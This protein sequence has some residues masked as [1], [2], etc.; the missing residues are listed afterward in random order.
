MVES[1]LHYSVSVA[2]SVEEVLSLL[3]DSA[4]VS[5]STTIRAPSLQSYWISAFVRNYGLDRKLA[6]TLVAN[7]ENHRLV[8]PFQILE[9]GSLSFVCDETSDYNDLMFHC[10]GAESVRIAFAH[11]LSTGIRRFVLTRLPH[12]ATTIAILEA[13]ARDLGLRSSVC[14]CDYLPV[15]RTSADLPVELWSGVDI[16][17]IHEFQKKL[18]VLNQK[19]N[20][21]FHLV[22]TDVELSIMLPQ[23]MQLH[24]ERWHAQ[25]NVSKFLDS[26]RC[27]FTHD[28]CKAALH[29]GELFAAL[30]L[31]DGVIGSYRLGFRGGDTIFEWN[32][33]FASTFRKW[34]PGALLLLMILHQA[35]ELGY[36]KY[37]LMRGEEPYKYYWTDQR[38]HTITVTLQVP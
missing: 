24:V 26:R 20:V 18:R 9:P 25:G 7:N 35:K 27:N 34:S 38:E 29:R 14:V 10:S 36:R 17:R 13:V 23:M 12:D 31:I 11:W 4:G 6:F 37:N 22:E 21:T 1:P 5:A 3:E 30:M 28:I 32:T 8:A 16:S 19:S 15:L 33:S 2:T